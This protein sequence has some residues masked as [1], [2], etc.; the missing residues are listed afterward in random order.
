V[1]GRGVGELSDRERAYREFMAA[2]EAAKGERMFVR[3]ERCGR[4]YDDATRW[5]VCPHSPL[6][7]PPDDLCPR[8]DTLRSVHGPCPH[9][10]PAAAPRRLDAALTA[11][12]VAL[13]A[14]SLLAAA[15][16]VILAML[17]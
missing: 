3:C 2:V 14:A 7:F 11:A 1:G 4:C 6:G 8:C 17:G 5:T 13:L 9:R 10:G 16:T 12:G 15:A